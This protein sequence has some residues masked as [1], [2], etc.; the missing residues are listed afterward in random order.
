MQKEGEKEETRVREKRER[1]K[2]ERRG[3]MMGKLPPK[4]ERVGEIL[5]I[6]PVL[7]AGPRQGVVLVFSLPPLQ[8]GITRTSDTDTI[9]VIIGISVAIICHAILLYYCYNTILYC[10]YSCLSG[11]S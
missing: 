2:K 5:V 1:K 7:G 4:I 9:Q 8:A 6:L 10:C 3:S 11:S